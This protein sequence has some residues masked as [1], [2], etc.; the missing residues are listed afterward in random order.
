MERSFE[1]VLSRDNG[2]DEVRFTATPELVRR[3]TNIDQ[4]TVADIRRWLEENADAA[5][6]AAFI[7]RLKHPGH[8]VGPDG[9]REWDGV[10][11]L[12]LGDFPAT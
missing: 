12:G 4:P 5:A 9:T 6:D 10:V 8:A 1:P 3:E 7:W 11:R 2:I